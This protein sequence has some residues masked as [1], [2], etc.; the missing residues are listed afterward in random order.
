MCGGMDHVVDTS[1]KREL[2][3][4]L[5][6]SG[7]GSPPPQPYQRWNPCTNQGNFPTHSSNNSSLKNL[8]FNQARVNEELNIK[9]LD[10]DKILGKIH[11]KLNTFSLA[12][13]N[14]INFN[15]KLENQLA[16]L[17]AKISQ[18]HEKV[19]DV[20]TRGGKTTR[21]PPYPDSTKKNMVEEEIAKEDTPIVPKEKGKNCPKSFTSHPWPPPPWMGSSFTHSMFGTSITYR[22]FPTSVVSHR[23]KP[24]SIWSPDAPGIISNIFTPELFVVLPDGPLFSW[25]V[26]RR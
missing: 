4:L 15:K 16:C 24:H 25:T 17:T 14:Q 3:S 18:D 5:N 23:N 7:Y 26:C 20:T 1:P 13:K 8:V 22:S 10:H 6:D 19:N 9:L 21:D 12:L 2:K 11:D